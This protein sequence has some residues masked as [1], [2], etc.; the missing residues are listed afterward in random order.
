M[1]SK[2]AVALLAAFML[3]AALCEAAVLS[4]M[5]AELRCQCIKTHSA[6]FS[7]KYIKELRVI[8]SGP[9]CPNSEIIVKLLKG[10]EVCLDPKEKWVQTIVQVFLKRAEK[11]GQ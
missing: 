9:H 7:P 2:L 8:E 6:R 1:T 5:G 4:R 11:Q 10:T 3:S